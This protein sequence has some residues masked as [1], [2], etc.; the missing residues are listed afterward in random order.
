MVSRYNSFGQHWTGNP[1][2]IETQIPMTRANMFAAT[3]CDGSPLDIVA[4]YTR[5]SHSPDASWYIVSTAAYIQ[6]KREDSGISQHQPL[7]QRHSHTLKPSQHQSSR[8]FILCLFQIL[9]FSSPWTMT[10][11]VLTY[12]TK[13]IRR[14]SRPSLNL[15]KKSSTRTCDPH[16]QERFSMESILLPSRPVM[17]EPRPRTSKLPSKVSS[18]RWTTRT[19]LASP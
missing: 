6:I 15:S 10:C 2:G 1:S 4:A 14:L 12:I 7:S 17:V 18:R 9:R 11:M 19:Q 16:C 5:V 3:K 8:D 13:C